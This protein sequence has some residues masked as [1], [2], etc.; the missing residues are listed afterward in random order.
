M[1]YVNTS[2]DSRLTISL[3]AARIARRKSSCVCFQ[4]DL[5]LENL[6]SSERRFFSCLGRNSANSVPWILCLAESK[7]FLFLFADRSQI[8]ECLSNDCGIKVR[9]QIAHGRR[10]GGTSVSIYQEL[11][12]CCD[13]PVRQAHEMRPYIEQNES[14]RSKPVSQH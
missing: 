3:R 5:V 7:G 14:E 12:G 9:A 1:V 8:F 4:V 11:I 13:S 6:S 10:M 2:E